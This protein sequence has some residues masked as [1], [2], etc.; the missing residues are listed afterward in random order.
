MSRNVGDRAVTAEFKNAPKEKS[1]KTNHLYL[2]RS[3]LSHYQQGEHDQA[4]SE[5]T[6]LLHEEPQ[7]IAYLVA[8]AENEIAD[9][10][11]SAAIK[12]LNEPLLTYPNNNSLT[13]LY[14]QALMLN[15]TPEPALKLL[16]NLIRSEHYTPETYKLLAKAE[17]QS[18]RE[19]FAYEAMGNYYYALREINSSINHF[20]QALKQ[21][22]DDNFREIQLKARISQLKTELLKLRTSQEKP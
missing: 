10:K 11:Y 19:S 18:G 17:K 5:L 2:Y 16:Q 1:R 9:K 14:A 8:T 22:G 20:E 15:K 3:A 12:A 13:H 4:R 6:R 21:N 7:R